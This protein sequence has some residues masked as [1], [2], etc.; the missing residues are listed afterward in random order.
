MGHEISGVVELPA[1]GSRYAAGDRVVVYPLLPCRRCLP[2]Q[3]GDYAQCLDYDYFGSRRH[4]GFAEHLYVPEANL[5]P[6]PDHVDLLQACLTEPCA[7]ALHGANHLD[8]RPGQNAAVFGGGPVGNMAAQWLLLRGASPVFVVD[9]DPQKLALA[10]SM[11]MTP[12]QASEDP[13]RAILEAT[14]GLGADRVLEAVGLP[15]TFLQ[16]VQC[17]ARFA[18]VVFLGNIRGQLEISEKEVSSILRR[19]LRIQG[20]WNSRFH[21]AGSNDWTTVLKFM[22]GRL[23][24]AEL[25]SHTPALEE[26]PEIFRALVSGEL[27]SHGKIVFRVSGDQ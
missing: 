4:G 25:I 2:C 20:T 6:V 17:A 5:L 18:Q 10:Q 14:G 11:G 3:T 15:L 12:V 24:I 8:I 19:E 13:V 9:V 22:G 16:A 27:G 1:A 23:R 21:P 26:G 7:V